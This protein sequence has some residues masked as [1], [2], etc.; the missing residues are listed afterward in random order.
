VQLFLRLF[1][2]QP[3]TTAYRAVRLVQCSDSEWQY[4]C[5]CLVD[6]LIRNPPPSLKWLSRLADSDATHV[7]V[8]KYFMLDQYRFYCCEARLTNRPPAISV[9][10][11]SW[12]ACM[13]CSQAL[14]I[15]AT[16]CELRFGYT[17]RAEAFGS[18]V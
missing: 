10:D 16:W 7:E 2:F 15:V 3:S 12:L 17:T 6:E 14:H 11:D 13:W 1:E 8:L 18:S 4:A 9:A 5:R